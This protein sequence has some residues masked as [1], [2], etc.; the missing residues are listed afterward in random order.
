MSVLFLDDQGNR[1]GAHGRCFFF[2]DEFYRPFPVPVHFTDAGEAY[3]DVF[4]IA[5]MKVTT[6]PTQ[7]KSG[8]LNVITV[9]SNTLGADLGADVIGTVFDAIHVCAIS[10]IDDLTF[11]D[12]LIGYG[13]ITR[14]R[15][16]RTVAYVLSHVDEQS[17]QIADD[18]T[19]R[20][21]HSENQVAKPIFDDFDFDDQSTARK[22]IDSH[23]SVLPS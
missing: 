9:L 13:T 3:T 11:C 19:I 1:L 2:A 23:D 18:Q 15:P 22:C 17:A 7:C 21:V 14:D 6:V 4:D 12:L 10:K 8:V 16:T 5:N 20:H